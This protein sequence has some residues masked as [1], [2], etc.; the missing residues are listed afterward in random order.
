ME[1]GVVQRR[2]ERDLGGREGAERGRA[3]LMMM[4]P[5]FRVSHAFC[6]H[7]LMNIQLGIFRTP[8]ALSLALML[9]KFDGV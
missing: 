7:I 3:G 5:W 9:C 1:R 2:C 6:V 8:T 4:M